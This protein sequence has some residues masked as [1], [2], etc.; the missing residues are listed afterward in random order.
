[1]WPFHRRRAIAQQPI[2]ITWPTYDMAR[3]DPEPGLDYCGSTAERLERIRRA[4]IARHQV[5]ADTARLTEAARMDTAEQDRRRSQTR[6]QADLEREQDTAVEDRRQRRHHHELA[7]LDRARERV[8][9]HHP[10]T[11]V[12]IATAPAR[13]GTQR[14]ESQDDTQDTPADAAVEV[15]AEEV[16]TQLSAREKVP[17]IGA[18]AAEFSIGKG[19][20]A[21]AKKMVETARTASQDG[22]DGNRPLRAVKGE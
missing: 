6:H 4:E 5:A 13:P 19:K 3:T 2:T 8:A 10:A 18:I 22:Q 16:F 7:A 12:Q 21:R 11:P 1:M 14:D 20:A 15:T 9:R 17:G